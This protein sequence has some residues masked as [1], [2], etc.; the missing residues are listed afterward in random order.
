MKRRSAQTK[1]RFILVKRR[2]IFAFWRTEAP[3]P[4]KNVVFV[5]F[6]EQKCIFFKL[7][8]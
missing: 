1:R 3:K 2:F 8:P 5:C 4:K 7:F 6:D